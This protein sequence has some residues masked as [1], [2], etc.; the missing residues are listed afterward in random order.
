[1]RTQRTH[2]TEQT[3]VLNLENENKTII[4]QY[5]RIISY[6]DISEVNVNFSNILD[7]KLGMSIVKSDDIDS[8]NNKTD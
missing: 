2:Q 3:N 4:D 6:K 5:N 1:M 7:I 8:R